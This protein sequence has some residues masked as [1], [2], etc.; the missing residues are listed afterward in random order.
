MASSQ[1]SA[2][3]WSWICWSLTKSFNIGWTSLSLISTWF[4]LKAACNAASSPLLTVTW[5]C[6]KTSRMDWNNR[7]GSKVRPSYLV[8]VAC[9]LRKSATCF[10]SAS[11]GIGLT[12]RL[13]IFSIGMSTVLKTTVTGSL[14]KTLISDVLRTAKTSMLKRSSNLAASTLPVAVPKLQTTAA[15]YL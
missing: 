5:C 10:K 4:S 2:V 15:W 11:E 9:W 7:V 12:L 14:R 6:F 8:N 13:G 1:S 3:C